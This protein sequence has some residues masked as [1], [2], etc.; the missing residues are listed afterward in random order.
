MEKERCCETSTRIGLSVT[1]LPGFLAVNVFLAKRN[2]LQ[3]VRT[4][5]TTSYLYLQ[6]RET[7]G[8]KGGKKGKDKHQKQENEKHKQ[9]DKEKIDKQPKAKP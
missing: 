8:D 9:K 3:R 1:P 6:R 2:A 5:T 4:R 7:M